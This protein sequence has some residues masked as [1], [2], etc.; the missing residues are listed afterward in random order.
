MSMQRQALG[1]SDE[2]ANRP[3]QSVVNVQVVTHGTQDAK[4]VV[5]G[6]DKPVSNPVELPSLPA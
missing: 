2:V 6:S 5:G 1:L 3:T 4:R